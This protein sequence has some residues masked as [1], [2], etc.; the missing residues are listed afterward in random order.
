MKKKALIIGSSK[1]IGK[2][3]L[4]G[5]KGMEYEIINPTS[6]E[7][8]TSKI[9]SI[10]KYIKKLKKIDVLILNTGGP[11]A[12]NFFQITNKEWNQYYN[13]LFLGFVKILQLIKINDGGYIFAV[14]SHTIKKPEDNLVLSNSFRVAFSSVFKTYSKLVSKKKISCINIAPGPIK[15]RRLEQLA[16]NLNKFE[17]KLPMKY[18]ANPDEIGNF[19]KSIL[20]NK[21]KYLNGVTINFDGGLSDFLF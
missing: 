3:I 16:K 21:I 12:K 14:T 1:G 11:P 10:L 6:K 5:I 7:L 17:K 19:V 2:S 8:D 15:T 9:D 18:A 20:I 13:Q 4:A